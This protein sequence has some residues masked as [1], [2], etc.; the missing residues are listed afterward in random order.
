MLAQ[1]YSLVK[2]LAK[3]D[4][5]RMTTLGD[6]IKRQRDEMGWTQ[7]ELAE[8]VGTSAAY[9]SQIV[10]G[11]TKLPGADL[12]RRI[13]AAFGVSHLDLLLLAGEI[14]EDELIESG[15]EG[16]RPAMRPGSETLHRLID[17]IDWEGN[18]QVRAIFETMLQSGF[19]QGAATNVRVV[20]RDLPARDQD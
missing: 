18:P 17:Q 6:W 4:S 7:R 8:H 9:M 16:R 13:A 1:S 2:H 5:G 12:R 15:K 19:D 3:G 10:N 20:P 11:G 14:E